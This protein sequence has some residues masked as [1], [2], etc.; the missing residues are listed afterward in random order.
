M[1]ENR[2]RGLLGALTEMD[3]I[4]R[5][6]GCSSEES[7]VVGQQRSADRIAEQK[8]RENII[9]VDFQTRAVVG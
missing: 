4:R 1:D 8:A 5:E 6:L 2:Y 9:R 7:M 3:D